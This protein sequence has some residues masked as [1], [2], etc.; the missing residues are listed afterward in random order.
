MR[1]AFDAQPTIGSATGIGEYA[2]ELRRA[3]GELPGI[4]LVPL[5]APSLD[6]WRFD[7]RAYWDQ[8]LLPIAAARSHATILHC[9]SGTMPAI[10]KVPIVL[11]LH[12]AAWLRVQGHTRFYARAYFGALMKRL[13][14]R[15][16]EIVTVSAFSAREILE[17][18]PGIDERH[19]HVIPLGVADEFANL[20]LGSGDGATILVVGTVE[21]RKNLEVVIRALPALPGVRAIS[22]GP[23]TPY[24]DACASIARELGVEDRLEFRGYVGRDALLELYATSTVLAMPSRYEGFG[25]PLAQARCAGLPAIAARGS[26]LDEIA[27]DSVPRIDAD[28][29]SAWSEALASLFADPERARR[30]AAADRAAAVDRFSWRRAAIATAELYRIAST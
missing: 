30:A 10:S 3:L 19:V 1:V 29:V 9:T 11:T 23:S 20:R 4:D 5:S 12:D 6:P 22:V 8:V 17:L 26:S 14:A 25:L 13:A 2:R 28:D 18:H 21:A 7:R 15:A 16:R 27:G 24:R